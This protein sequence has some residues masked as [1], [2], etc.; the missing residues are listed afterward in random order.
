MAGFISSLHDVSSG[1]IDIIT[2]N[3]KSHCT[4]L[5]MTNIPTDNATPTRNYVLN[6]CDVS[7]WCHYIYFL[8]MYN[9]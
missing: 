2:M 5:E 9:K 3:F 7:T 6:W 4:I 8:V 1:T